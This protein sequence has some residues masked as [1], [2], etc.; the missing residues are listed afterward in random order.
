MPLRA[1]VVDAVMVLPRQR[2]R[3]RKTTVAAAA[4]DED[5]ITL[6]AEAT[7][8]LLNRTPAK[9]KALLLATV[10]APLCEGGA[11]QMVAELSG[12]AGVGLHVQEHGGTIAATGSALASAA[13]LIKSGMAPVVVVTADTRRDT[14]GTPFGDGAVAMLLDA[15]GSLGSLAVVGSAAEAFPDRWRA[16]DQAGVQAGDDSLLPFGPA[17]AHRSALVADSDACTLITVD[18]PQ[19][20]RAG[21]LGCAALPATLLLSGGGPVSLVVS[22]GGITHAVRFEPGPDFAGAS[23]DAH[24][25]LSG[26]VDEMVQPPVV[27]VAGFDPYASVARTWRE[28]RQDLAL[29]GARCVDCGRVLFPVPPACPYDGPEAKL[30]PWRLGRTGTVLTFTRDHL[31]PLG[32]PLTMSVVDVDGGGRFYGQ[33]AGDQ[34]VRIGDRV[35]LVPRLLHEGGGR[36]QYYWKVRPMPDETTSDT[37]ELTEST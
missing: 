15:E 32:A 26:G 22:A 13:G 10:S 14:A 1:G 27:R 31:F 7:L 25:V 3:R 12:L 2:I 37:P 36:R 11:V 29:E 34:T 5:A 33:V 6:A 28:R 23:A 4:F 16:G 24:A 9:P 19:I 18:G 20:D 21:L 8:E 17:A 35:Q 30:E